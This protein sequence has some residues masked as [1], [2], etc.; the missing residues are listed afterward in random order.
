MKAPATS[1]ISLPW[2]LPGWQAIKE[3]VDLT[4]GPSAAG[5]ALKPSLQELALVAALQGAE[6]WPK[7][8]W[9]AGFSWC[10]TR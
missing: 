6:S 9:P 5:V 8:C 1:Q 4:A 2:P 3:V 7:E 10:R